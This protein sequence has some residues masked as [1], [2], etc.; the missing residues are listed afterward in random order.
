M[1]PCGTPLIIKGYN[2]AQYVVS[3]AQCRRAL[4]RR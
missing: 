1:D 3:N 2:V 4:E